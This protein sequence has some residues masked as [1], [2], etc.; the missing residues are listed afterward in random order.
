MSAITGIGESLDDRAQ[1]LGVLVAR[2]GDAHEVG[3]RLGDRRDLLHRGLEV[4]RL[5]LRHRLHG[6][7]RAAADQDAAD[8]HLAL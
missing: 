8:V 1:R 4:R 6:D 3:A 2:H 7:R 5:G